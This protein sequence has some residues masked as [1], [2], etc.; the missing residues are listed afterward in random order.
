MRHVQWR[1]AA[2]LALALIV[3]P[4]LAIAAWRAHPVSFL[5]T[6]QAA[7]E[8][9]VMI[10]VSLPM[11]RAWVFRQGQLIGTSTVS[12]GRARH[13]TPAGAYTILQKAVAHRSNLYGNAPMPYMQR[14]TWGG[15]ALHAGYVTGRPASHGCI[16]LPRAFARALFGATAL[17]TE[18]IVTREAPA[19]AEEALAIAAMAP[20]PARIEPDIPALPDTGLTMTETVGYW[21]TAKRVVVHTL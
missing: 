20:V 2:I 5:W 18:V 12:T 16:R 21:G 3:I 11:Q 14:L 15:V 6:P 1:R 9:P 13:G 10:V 19:T 8:G 7:P 17:G 4:Q